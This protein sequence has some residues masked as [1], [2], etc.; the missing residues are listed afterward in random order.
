MAF[1]YRESG[2]CLTFIIKQMYHPIKNTFWIY[3]NKLMIVH[4]LL[5]LHSKRRHTNLS[6]LCDS[7]YWNLLVWL[8]LRGPERVPRGSD[9]R[10]SIERWAVPHTEGEAGAEGRQTEDRDPSQD[11]EG[12]CRP[13]PG[14]N[15]SPGQ[16]PHSVQLPEY[17]H[18]LQGNAWIISGDYLHWIW[19]TME[20]WEL[21]LIFL[22]T[23]LFMMGLD[24]LPCPPADSN[25]WLI[26]MYKAYLAY[27]LLYYLWKDIFLKSV[28]NRETF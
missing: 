3:L 9:R 22:A 6:Q 14:S 28:L 5:H 18:T 25:H 8:A 21:F 23:V 19:S 15:S 24:G 2:V 16:S 13:L 1:F 11:S 27:L 12:F 10:R 26:F 4:F 20:L 17:T 7:Y